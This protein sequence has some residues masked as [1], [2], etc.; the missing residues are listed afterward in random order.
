MTW[1]WKAEESFVRQIYIFKAKIRKVLIYPEQVVSQKTGIKNSQRCILGIFS[2][3]SLHKS[4]EGSEK[5]FNL[6]LI[7]SQV[8]LT[9]WPMLFR[10]SPEQITCR[11]E[12]NAKSQHFSL[13]DFGRSEAGVLTCKVSEPSSIALLYPEWPSSTATSI[14]GWV[15]ELILESM[16]ASSAF[17]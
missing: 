15:R 17:T 2:N 11:A 12:S 7:Y 6:V 13:K 3:L 5:K 14:S 10:I 8:P 9:G 16:A 4:H 1:M